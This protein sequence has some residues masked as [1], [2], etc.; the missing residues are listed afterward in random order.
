MSRPDPPGRPEQ[1][2]RR[3][4]AVVVVTYRTRELV[5]RC[6]ESVLADLPPGV[7]ARIIVVDN[8]SGDGTVEMFRRDFPEV[9]V[10]ANAENRGPAAAYNQGVQTGLEADFILMLNSDIELL[11]GTIGPMLDYLHAHPEVSG[12]L[13]RL[14]NPDGTPQYMRVQIKQWHEP[15]WDRPFAATFVSTCFL[16]A[17]REAFLRVGLFDE[18]YYFHNED[19]DWSER[20]TR[21]GLRF[22][23]LPSVRVRHHGS[24]GK[25]QNPGPI[26]AALFPSN[27]YYFHKFY[28]PV[29]ARLA[30]WA[31]LL[32]IRLELRKLAR[33]AA[34]SRDPAERER[35]QQAME[36]YK[37][38]RARMLA[39]ARSGK[40]PHWRPDRPDR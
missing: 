13:G 25:N 20:A 27:L 22:M 38:G 15:P 35:L 24:A 6:V 14:Y 37:A 4:L 8:A 10:I 18:A 1:G 12:V 36:Y 2:G 19:L 34:A 40:L 33:E 39:L 30:L 16:M 5:R 11:P 31:M 9:Q 28:G 23:Y 7:P 29:A 26:L 3:E 21:L 32:Q 17:R